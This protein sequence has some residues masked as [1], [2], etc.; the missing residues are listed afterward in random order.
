M[1]SSLFFSSGLGS[2]AVERAFEK[3]RRRKMAGKHSMSRYTTEGGRV[4]RRAQPVEV[5]RLLI[6]LVLVYE[7]RV[8][9][10]T[11]L[12]I[13]NCW[14]CKLVNNGDALTTSFGPPPLSPW[15]SL[16]GFLVWRQEYNV[17]TYRIQACCFPVVEEKKRATGRGR[18]ERQMARFS[19][20]Q[21]HLLYTV[22]YTFGIS[23]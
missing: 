3:R 2:R 8:Q 10:K 13:L 9:K 4:R 21:M 6:P 14:Q 17:W 23:H 22:H 1:I 20:P 19:N 18:G 5:P 7:P 16:A 12:F 11:L 15:S